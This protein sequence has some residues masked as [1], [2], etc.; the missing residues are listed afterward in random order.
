MFG[1][2][3]FLALGNAGCTASSKYMLQA[4]KGSGIQRSPDMATVVFVRPS[5]YAAAVKTTILDTH[6]RFLGDALPSA[7]F[8]VKVPPG[9][10]VFLSWAENTAALRATLEANKIYFVEVSSKMG[11]FSPRM[12]L[13]AIAPRKES[14]SK[15]DS[16]LGDC[17]AYSVDERAGQA[18]LRERTADTT[19]R[20]ERAKE[21]LTKYSAEE[22]DDRTI[23]ASDAR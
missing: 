8:A 7:Y 21:A 19:E 1:L 14:W 16:W 4:P 20:I 10:H 9:Q 15:L 3:V 18:Y 2:G 13:L 6:G 23:L 12:H 11:A 22:L 17:E 5:G